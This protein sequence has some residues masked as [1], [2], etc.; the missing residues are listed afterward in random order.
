MIYYLPSCC[1]S[2]SFLLSS[3]F[4]TPVGHTSSLSRLP[5]LL[6]GSGCPGARDPWLMVT[7]SS[8]ARISLLIFN[9]PMLPAGLLVSLWRTGLELRSGDDLYCTGGDCDLCSISLSFRFGSSSISNESHST[10]SKLCWLSWDLTNRENHVRTFR[11]LNISLT[12]SY[13]FPLL[14]LLFLHFEFQETA[15][16]VDT[17]VVRSRRWPPPLTDP[18]RL[19][20]SVRIHQMMRGVGVTENRLQ[21]EWRGRWWR[22][23]LCGSWNKSNI[24]QMSK[25]KNKQWQKVKVW[26]LPESRWA[27]NWDSF[28]SPSALPVNQWKTTCF[29]AIDCRVQE[30]SD[31]QRISPK[32]MRRELPKIIRSL[33]NKMIFSEQNPEKNFQKT[34][35][36]TRKESKMKVKSLKP[37]DKWTEKNIEKTKTI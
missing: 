23:P 30:W 2:M 7:N 22:S 4:R 15:S 35:H 11:D 13:F 27:Q 28:G 36:S 25:A 3:N 18:H 1:W 12:F 21:R 37:N 8:F 9:F 33:K 29:Q 17:I 32:I 20:S 5:P 34:N 10:P 6:P 16:D 19:G 24:C 14:Q 31:M 26:A